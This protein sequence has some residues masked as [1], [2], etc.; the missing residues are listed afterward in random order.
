[1]LVHYFILYPF[2]LNFK[3]SKETAS[4]EKKHA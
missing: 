4:I 2:N 1:M 3:G